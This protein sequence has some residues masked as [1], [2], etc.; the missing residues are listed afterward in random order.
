MYFVNGNDQHSASSLATE[1]DL[2][3]GSLPVK[4]LGVPLMPH[5][6]W[7]QDY[8]PLVDKIRSRVTSWTAKQLS[9]AGDLNSRLQVRSIFGL[10]FVPLAKECLEK[11]RKDLYH[12]SLD[13]SSELARGEKVSWETVCSPKEWGVLGL[14]CLMKLNLVY[15]IKLIWLLF[16][17][18]ESLW[19]S[20]ICSWIWRRLMKLSYL[21]KPFILYHV[22]SGRILRLFGITIGWNLNQFW[23][24][25]RT[26][27]IN[28]LFCH[29]R[30]YRGC[31]EDVNGISFKK[32][33]YKGKSIY[34]IWHNIFIYKERYFWQ[35]N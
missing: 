19:V 33:V 35:T 9:F 12:L 21:A 17:G 11:T 23:C 18:S 5:K 13:R 14:L 20:N 16:A 34:N 7:S 15:G 8:Q 31:V 26:R 1:L 27:S 24:H 10:Q 22:N 6:L 4:Y 3:Q 29:W 25:R 2:V 28:W 30:R 32:E